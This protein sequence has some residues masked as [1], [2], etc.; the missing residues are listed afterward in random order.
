MSA[1]T[2]SNPDNANPTVHKT[3]QETSS[4]S[5]Y[6]LADFLS[7]AEEEDDEDLLVGSSSSSS[8]RN[9]KQN[10]TTQD[11]VMH[12]DG[13]TYEGDSSSSSSDNENERELIDSQEI[14]G[15]ESTLFTELTQTN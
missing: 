13:L 15:G 1:L 2:T 8:R 6:R 12:E 11:T 9:S 10:I 4:R 14:F 5:R 3:G 7:D